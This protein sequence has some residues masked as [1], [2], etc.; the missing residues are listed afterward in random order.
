M[1]VLLRHECL[2]PSQPWG[3]MTPNVIK[4]V[5]EK[6]VYLFQIFQLIRKQIWTPCPQGLCS[7]ALWQ[8]SW[9]RLSDLFLLLPRFYGAHSLSRFL[10]SRNSITHSLTHVGRRS[11]LL[12]MLLLSFP[13]QPL[14]SPL[15][16]SSQPSLSAGLPPL[17][18]PSVWLLAR[19]FL[20]WIPQTPDLPLKSPQLN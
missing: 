8:C 14:G 16:R 13:C 11:S 17:C 9:H 3:K 4:W 15:P 5:P 10:I 12:L 1:V 6:S 7:Q 2:S 19:S 20:W 18:H